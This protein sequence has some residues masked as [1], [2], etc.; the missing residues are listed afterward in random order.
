MRIKLTPQGLIFQKAKKC[1]LCGRKYYGEECKRTHFNKQIL[2]G[3]NPQNTFHQVVERERQRDGSPI[4][5]HTWSTHAPSTHS[6]TASY[7]TYQQPIPDYLLPLESK[8]QMRDEMNRLYAQLQDLQLSIH[9]MGG[10]PSRDMT[11]YLKELAQA[12]LK[13]A[14]IEAQ[15][16]LR[17]ESKK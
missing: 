1:P 7:A 10:I 3:Y 14:D 2:W 4:C 6:Y 13:G 8:D 15:V 9:N 17:H 5:E 16:R 12:K 11:D